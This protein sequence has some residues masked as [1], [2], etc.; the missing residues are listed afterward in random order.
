MHG[1]HP[2]VAEVAWHA[3][4]RGL[5]R[6]DAV[7]FEGRTLEVTVEEMSLV[8]PA[9]AGLPAQ[10]VF[11]VRDGGGRRLRITVDAEGRASVEIEADG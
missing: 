7:V 8:G 2:A 3:G 5:E 11:I 1:W 9:V 4:H 10:R 6:P